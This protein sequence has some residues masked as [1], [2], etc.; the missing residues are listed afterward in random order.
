MKIT[1]AHYAHMKQAM[2]AVAD[3]IPAI[4]DAIAADP[5]VRDADK[6]LRWDLFNDAGLTRW[7]CDNVYSYANDDHVDTALRAIMKEI[8]TEPKPEAEAGQAFGLR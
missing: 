1:P 2:S 4:R 3:R 6:R 5:R 7:L 8:E